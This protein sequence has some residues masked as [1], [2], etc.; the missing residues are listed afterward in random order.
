MDIHAL[1]TDSGEDVF[2]EDAFRNLL[3]SY[4]PY[5]RRNKTIAQMSVSINQ[6]L[7]F[8]GDFYGL[9]DELKISKKYH[10]IVMRL[11]NL[12]NSLNYKSSVPFIFLP[13]FQK[14]E[15]MA[16]VY[17]SSRTNL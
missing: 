14:I 7:V 12:T 2:Y 9:L 4:M 13:D 6:Q 15:Q 10:Y 5:F 1:M 16:S 11:N 8:E 3:E 17:S